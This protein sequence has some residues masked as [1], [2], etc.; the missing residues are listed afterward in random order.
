MNRRT[1]TLAAAA[2]LAALLLL[3]GCSAEVELAENE[4][5]NGDI[6]LLAGGVV[7]RA[8]SR[9]E[10]GISLKAGGVEIANGCAVAGGVKVSNG[11]IETYGDLQTPRLHVSNGAIEAAAGTISGDLYVGNGAIELDGTRVKGMVELKRGRIDV[12]DGASLEGGLRV[13]AGGSFGDSTIVLIG[14]GCR[15]MGEVAVTGRA[16]LLIDPGA[17]ISG[18]NFTGIKPRISTAGEAKP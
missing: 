15:L 1:G 12:T 11:A 18:A 16:R 13:D 6:Q 9:L 4:I 2:A 10:G 14:P 7:M 8:G 17:D 5:R 3:A